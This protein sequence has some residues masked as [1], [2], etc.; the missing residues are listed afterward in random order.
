MFINGINSYG[1]GYYNYQAAINNARLIDALSRNPKLQDA[2]K[3][4]SPSNSS[5]RNSFD[6]VKEYT[7]SMSSL[8]QAAMDQRADAVQWTAWPGSALEAQQALIDMRDQ[9]LGGTKDVSTAMD[10]AQEKVQAFIEG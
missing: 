6:F 9:I 8:M 1:M 7:S 10:E 2:V 3:S 4:V 5:L